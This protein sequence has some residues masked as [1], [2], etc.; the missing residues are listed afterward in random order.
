MPTNIEEKLSVTIDT[1]PRTL[2]P[3]LFTTYDSITKYNLHIVYEDE[4]T[5][6]IELVQND[7]TRPYKFIFKR[8]GRLVTAI[9]VPTIHEI[10]ECN[11][12]CDFANKIMDSNDL[13][14][15]LDCSSEYE[16]TK[17]RFYLKDV[18]DIVDLINEPIDD[19]EEGMDENHTLY[20]I[21]LNGYSCKDL[22]PCNVSEKNGIFTTILS[23]QITKLDA[24]LSKTDYSDFDIFTLDFDPEVIPMYSQDETIEKI[25]LTIPE[26]LIGTQIS[27]IIRYFVNEI[28]HP[29]FD[30]FTILPIKNMIES[31]N[32]TTQ[33]V[34]TRAVS[35]Q[36]MQYLGDGL[37]PALGVGV[38]PGYKE[39][40]NKK[41]YNN[42]VL[43][44][45]T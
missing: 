2:K 28:D 11:K 7:K 18:R 38:T 33:P 20:P 35:T 6:D 15:E 34:L 42:S 14:I 8:E 9:G 23:S 26:E 27:I 4:T 41:S 22:V 5:K 36:D 21:Y 37:K 39:Y 45:A 29:V 44:S 30:E 10:N 24:P 19:T 17:V 32:G 25:G 13:L 1:N 12:M 16:C 3:I 40:R 31:D 43:E